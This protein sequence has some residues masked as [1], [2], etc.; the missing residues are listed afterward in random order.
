MARPRQFNREESLKNAM[1]VFWEKGYEATSTDDLID[2]MGIGRQSMYGA[3]SDK[4]KLY[5]DALEMYSATTGAELFRRLYEAKSPFTALCNYI[6][7]IA[8]GTKTER[9]RGCMFVNAAV[10]L[11]SSDPDVA[12]MIRTRNEKSRTAFERII[13]EGKENG[14]VDSSVDEKIAAGYLFSTICGL[15]VSAKAGIPPTELRLIAELALSTLKSHKA[16]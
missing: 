3:F 10:E 14:E 6:L 5:L 16:K 2:A 9:A 8:E 15:R 11:A 12:E 7:G 13:S 4:H 1:V